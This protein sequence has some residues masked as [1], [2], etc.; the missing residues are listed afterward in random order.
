M[1]MPQ[2][3]RILGKYQS[4]GTGRA[5]GVK[6]VNLIGVDKIDTAGLQWDVIAA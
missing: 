5:G 4:T 1:V 6:T 3:D 2:G